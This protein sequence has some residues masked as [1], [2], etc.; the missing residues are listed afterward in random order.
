MSTNKIQKKKK[1]KTI[2]FALNSGTE[3]CTHSPKNLTLAVAEQADQEGDDNNPTNHGQADN[4]RLEVYC[5]THKIMMETSNTT[6]ATPFK[7][8]KQKSVNAL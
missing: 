3:D 4:Q 2:Y 7:T 5:Q 1:E 8:L 6:T